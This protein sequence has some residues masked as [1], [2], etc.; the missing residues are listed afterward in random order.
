MP[1]IKFEFR[2]F[3]VVLPK[4]ID[5]ISETNGAPM[6]RLED[7]ADQF[8]DGFELLPWLAP[9]RGRRACGR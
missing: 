3:F 8:A 9:A 4:L 5:N 6:D 1:A 7:A 2:E